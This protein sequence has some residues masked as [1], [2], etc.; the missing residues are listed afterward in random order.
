MPCTQHKAELNNYLYCT[1]ECMMLP[2]LKLSGVQF[3]VNCSYNEKKIEVK[4]LNLK[5][6]LEPDSLELS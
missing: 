6:I 4:C 5:L 2:F 3:T 1:A